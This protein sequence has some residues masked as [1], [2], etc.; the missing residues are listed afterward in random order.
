M[1]RIIIIAAM[2]MTSL[3][4]SAQESGFDKFLKQIWFPT[5]FG[6]SQPVAPGMKGGMMT[7]IALEWRQE[8]QSGIFASINYDTG[9]DGYSDKL[10]AGTNLPA[11]YAQHLSQTPFASSLAE[12]G[13]FEMSIGFT[14]A[15]F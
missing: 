1:K 3:Q 15:I 7:R 9:Y 5:E 6:Y 14:A 10:P 11:G 8:D 4:L 13:I 12:D 2:L